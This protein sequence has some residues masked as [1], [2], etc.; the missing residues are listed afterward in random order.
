MTIYK[1]KITNIASKD[2]SPLMAQVGIH[3][4]E[5]IR[6]K[7]KKLVKMYASDFHTNPKNIN[8][9]LTSVSTV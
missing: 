2:N 8:I 3:P 9:H 7:I 5:D 1:M 6:K 4:K